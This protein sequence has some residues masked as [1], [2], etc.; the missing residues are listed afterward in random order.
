MVAATAAVLFAVRELPPSGRGSS[1]AV[2]AEQ[3]PAPDAAATPAASAVPVLADDRGPPLEH[4]RELGDEEVAGKATATQRLDGTRAKPPAP[5]AKR[6]AAGP[7]R[8]P[9]AARPL[10]P[11]P[12]ATAAPLAALPGETAKPKKRE[13]P[14]KD[15]VAE[16]PA[17]PAP[18]P[19][20]APT[21]VAGAAG[22]GG[23]AS[24]AAPAEDSA[25]ADLAPSAEAKTE[26]E[27]PPSPRASQAACLRTARARGDIASGEYT[28]HLRY[29][30]LPSGLVEQLE[31]VAPARWR[32]SAIDRCLRRA[33][34]TWRLPPRAEALRV[35][36]RERIDTD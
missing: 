27:A 2:L 30:I 24:E 8:A 26:G 17:P 34:T 29:T 16:S 3:A 33:A 18:A 10:P 31:L 19:E 28:L 32:N 4:T 5:A 21:S 7:A 6:R 11:P 25:T 14:A 1:T 23:S 9:A 13:R 22:E 20:P 12:P 36:T 35:E 15:R